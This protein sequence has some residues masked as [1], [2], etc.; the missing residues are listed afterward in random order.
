M[1]VLTDF[2]G[3]FEFTELARGRYRLGLPTYPGYRREI[4][5]KANGCEA[6]NFPSPRSIKR[7]GCEWMVGHS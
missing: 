7:A 2:N 1:E 3:V 4:E 5:T 6:F